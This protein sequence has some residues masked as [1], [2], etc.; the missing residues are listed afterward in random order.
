MYINIYTMVICMYMYMSHVEVECRMVHR[1]QIV[2]RTTYYVLQV[3]KRTHLFLLHHVDLLVSAVALC[4]VCCVEYVLHSFL[5]EQW[6]Y[7]Y[8][9]QKLDNVAISAALSSNPKMSRSDRSWF[10]LVEDTAIGL[11]SCVTQ[12]RQ[13][14]YTLLLC[15]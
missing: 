6:H 3:S 13:T 4:T 8:N 11:P 1:L 14:W 9:L 2:L 10:R 15:A 7:N 12:R 5:V